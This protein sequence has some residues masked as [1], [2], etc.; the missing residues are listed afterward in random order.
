MFK[1]DTSTA[2]LGFQFPQ[3]NVILGKGAPEYYGG[4]T[5]EIGYRRWGLQ[6]F[7]TFSH[8]GHLLWTES[9]TSHSFY[10]IANSVVSMLD[11]YTPSHTS[12]RSPRLDLDAPLSFPTNLD[13]FGS[14]FFKLRSLVLN[15]QL[16]QPDLKIKTA[17]KALRLFVSATNLFTITEVSW[18]R[19]GDIRRRL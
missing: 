19:S 17:I 10:S 14:P 2:A 7:F 8:G 3:H 12:S 5:Q 9:V 13:V 11:R 4:M 6:C 18:Q 1:L 16:S 15:Y